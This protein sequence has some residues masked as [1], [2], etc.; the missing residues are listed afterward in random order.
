MLARAFGVRDLAIG[1]GAVIALDRGMPVR[2]WIEAGVLSDAVDTARA[3]SRAAPS[4]G[5][6]LPAIAIGAGSAAAGASSR[7]S[8]ITRSRFRA[9]TPESVSAE[10][11]PSGASGV[12]VTV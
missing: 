10:F 3:C 12:T 9:K 1:L 5:I 7:R 8:S 11:R 2:G 4:R 6:R